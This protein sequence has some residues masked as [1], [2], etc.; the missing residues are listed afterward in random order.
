MKPALTHARF[1]RAVDCAATLFDVPRASILSRQRPVVIARARLAVYAALYLA[2][3][4]SSTEI[5]QRVGRDHTTVLDGVR[6]A[7]QQAKANCEYA[8]HIGMIMQAVSA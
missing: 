1:L 6:R 4:A 2:L 3:D 5:A 8:E 7:M